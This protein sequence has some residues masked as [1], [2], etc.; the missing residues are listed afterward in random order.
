MLAHYCQIISRLGDLTLFWTKISLMYSQISS[1]DTPC[2]RTY[3]HRAFLRIM[4]FGTK[5]LN[6]IWVKGF[7]LYRL[8]A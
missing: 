1:A 6:N 3:A 8:T 2:T 7:S 4:I 5:Y